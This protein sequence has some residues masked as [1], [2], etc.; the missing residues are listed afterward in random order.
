M[1]SIDLL[2]SSVSQALS[3]IDSLRKY[4]SSLPTDTARSTA[5]Q[6]ITRLLLYHTAHHLG[7]SHV[8]L[9]TSLT[10]LAV[11]L[12]SSISQGGGFHVKEEIQ[13]EW[14]PA[15]STPEIKSSKA[16]SNRIRVIQP[17]RD[18]GMKECAAWAWWKDVTIVGRESWEWTGSKPG[19]GKLTKSSFWSCPLISLTL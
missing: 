7:C 19:I 8:V 18:V 13:E 15:E 16:R 1:I 3:P 9:G 14:T 11:S 4:L 6:T 12:I 10:S 2:R 5:L 17:L